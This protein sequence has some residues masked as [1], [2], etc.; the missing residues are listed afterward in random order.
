[1]SKVNVTKAAWAMALLGARK[2][3]NCGF[4][5]TPG[6]SIRTCNA[7]G[8]HFNNLRAAEHKAQQGDEGGR[9]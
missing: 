2:S 6:H 7:A 3:R 4:C 9:K 1:M 5:K 8:V